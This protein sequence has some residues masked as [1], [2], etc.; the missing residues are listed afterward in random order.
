MK[1]VF[2]SVLL[3]C[4][5]IL[6]SQNNNPTVA[7]CDGKQIVCA[8]SSKF[9]LCVNIVIDPSYSNLNQITSYTIEWGDGLPDTTINTIGGQSQPPFTH[10]YDLSTF[11]GTCIEKKEFYVTLYTNHTPS[12]IDQTNSIFKLIIKNYASYS[13]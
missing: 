3:C 9:T 10:V 2:F 1:Y 8:T 4:G 5:T 13:N 6:F 7:P 11:Y 12:S